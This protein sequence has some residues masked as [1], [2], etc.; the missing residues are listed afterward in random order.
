MA[1]LFF[2]GKVWGVAA[3]GAKSQAIQCF[4]E[5]LVLSP[6]ELVPAR[7]GELRGLLVCEQLLAPCIDVANKDFR[8]TAGLVVAVAT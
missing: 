4:F 3:P 5:Q 1:P 7:S 2:G 6:C 8:P